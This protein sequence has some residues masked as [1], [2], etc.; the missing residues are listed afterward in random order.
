[1]HRTLLIV[2]AIL[3]H[4]CPDAFCVDRRNSLIKSFLFRGEL[5]VPHGAVP[6]LI[7]RSQATI[8]LSCSR[9]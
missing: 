6:V 7:E 1:M 2:L 4:K 5:V 9:R 3:N 8:Q